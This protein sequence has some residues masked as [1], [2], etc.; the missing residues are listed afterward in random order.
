MLLL[1]L[2]LAVSHCARKAQPPPCVVQFPIPPP[3]GTQLSP[4][5]IPAVSPDGSRV[6]FTAAASDRVTRL[7]VQSLRRAV[8]GPVPGAEGAAFPFWSPD[9]EALGFFSEGR[10]K[11]VDL[12]SGTVQNLGAAPDG[13]GG[14]WSPRQVVIFSA[15]AGHAV[16]SVPATGGAIRQLT[17]LEND[18]D[19]QDAWPAFLPDGEHFLYSS[20]DKDDT[21]RIRL[22]SVRSSEQ[23]QVMGG[24]S[25][26]A[27]GPSSLFYVAD[28]D[29]LLLKIRFDPRLFTVHQPS[30]LIAQGIARGPSGLASFGASA[31]GSVIVYSRGGREIAWL[32]SEGHEARAIPDPGSYQPPLL[33]PS[34][35]EILVTIG[36]HWLGGGWGAFHIYEPKSDRWRPVSD[37][38]GG[39][40]RPLWAPDGA[41]IIFTQE[42][43][44]TTQVV[45][46]RAD[47]SGVTRKLFD[48]SRGG[49]AA[50]VSPKG[51]LMALVE[52][53]DPAQT[54]LHIRIVSL[55]R[56]GTV[57]ER[58]V[59]HIETAGSASDPAFSPDGSR[60]AFVSD[61]SGVHEVYVIDLAAQSAPVRVSTNGG[62]A[63]RWPRD[64]TRLFYRQRT[65]IAAV[66]TDG[67]PE[68]WGARGGTIFLEEDL[69]RRLFLTDFDVAPDGRRFLMLKLADPDNPAS[70]VGM[71][72]CAAAAP[73]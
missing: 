51:A 53:P 54:R 31:D 8:V 72:A 10:L 34:G 27:P 40:G 52:R 69:R 16:F 44:H 2:A 33:S 56:A 19:R 37:G 65:G 6:A 21:R 35:E 26:V 63:P 60:L 20:I 11:Q 66:A 38:V 5:Q 41:E 28:V 14:S 70:L 22:G 62:T 39:L 73:R 64:G 45:A 55:A 47:G 67:S 25:A 36:A 49:Y 61:H 3:P 30:A 18:R 43:D 57:E 68:A 58:T 48:E 42:N 9:G 71:A 32:D 29:D 1:I 15:G 13:R 46:V 59:R 23:G 12:R 24:T 50:A 17:N 7:W 4:R